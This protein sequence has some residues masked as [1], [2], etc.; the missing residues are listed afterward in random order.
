VF[1][2]G[3]LVVFEVLGV[4]CGLLENISWVMSDVCYGL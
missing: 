2:S 1:G 3:S 4:E